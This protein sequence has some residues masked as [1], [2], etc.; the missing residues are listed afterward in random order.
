MPSWY[1][2]ANTLA[3]SG[4]ELNATCHIDKRFPKLGYKEEKVCRLKASNHKE[5]VKCNLIA[6]NCLTVNENR[7]I[8]QQDRFTQRKQL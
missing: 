5:V 2:H 7:L 6:R 4:I 3:C 8:E 1:L